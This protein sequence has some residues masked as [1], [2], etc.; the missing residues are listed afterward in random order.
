MQGTEWQL[1]RERSL[2]GSDERGM[3]DEVTWKNAGVWGCTSADMSR[4]EVCL[5]HALRGTEGNAHNWCV[6]A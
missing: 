6:L 2:A 4:R 1:K 5:L 3:T